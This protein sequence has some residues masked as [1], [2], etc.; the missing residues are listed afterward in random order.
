MD[1]NNQYLFEGQFGLERETLRVT[2]DGKL[3]QTPHPFGDDKHLDRDFC[4]N[5]LELI[6]PVCSDIDELMNVLQRL[7]SRA[8]KVLSDMGEYLWMM[9]NPP[10]IECEDDIPIAKFG[11]DKSFKRDYR[12]NLQRRYGK[13]VMLYS[14]IHFNFSFSEQLINS[15]YDGG[16]TYTDFKND[17][18]FRLSKQVLRYGWLLTLLT[19]ASPVYDLSFD[20]DGLS[21]SGFD[22]YA[23]RRSGDKGYWNE[24]VP[25]LNYTNL[26]TYIESINDYIYKGALFSAGELYLPV[27]LKPRGN[28]SIEALDKNGVDHIELR[29][30]DLNPLAPQGVFREDLEFAHYFLIYLLHLP[31]FELTEEMQLRAVG[32]YKAASRYELSDII[33][34][35]KTVLS[36][37]SDILDDMKK[38]FHGFPRVVLSIERQK[39][40]IENNMRYC[41]VLYDKLIGDFHN[42]MLNI[43]KEYGEY[44][45]V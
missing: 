31:D 13:R 2:A 22:G 30:F 6:T 5:Q 10:H 38:Y 24:F 14:G 15:M 7:D 28:N 39:E 37:A 17:I 36:A 26:H 25:V 8:R 4:E 32:N 29:M 12:L 11:G 21:G 23:S 45:Y 27:R 42:T 41:T 44:L 19:A 18:Y 20:G 43:S 9:S 3:S 34:D 33:I 16:G 35:G 40:K 1:L